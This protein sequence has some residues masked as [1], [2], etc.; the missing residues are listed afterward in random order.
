MPERV[1]RLDDVLDLLDREAV[2]VDREREAATAR[3]VDVAGQSLR[4]EGEL[5]AFEPDRY[6]GGSDLVVGGA[7]RLFSRSFRWSFPLP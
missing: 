2:D 6:R 4:Q 1:V 7:L 5:A 3:S